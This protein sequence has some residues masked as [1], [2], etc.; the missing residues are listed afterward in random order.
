MTSTSTPVQTLRARTPED[1]LA[2]VPVVL[3][4]EP[5]E[6]VV[7]LTFGAAHPFHARVDLPERAAHADAVTHLLLDPAVQH[8]V[9]RVVLLLYTAADPDD[10]AVAATWRALCEGC[11]ERGLALVEALLVTE[12]R[13]HP[14]LGADGSAPGVRYDVSSHPFRAQA[15]LDGQV[16]RRSRD[17]LA[18]GIVADRAG[19]AR[20]A[21]A[22]SGLDGLGR[23]PSEEDAPRVLLA[24][25]EWVAA[26]VRRH[27]DAGTVPDDAEA[28]RLLR[29][30]GVVP[31]RDAAWSCL[32][33]AR[34]RESVRLL[35]DLVTRAPA[36]VLPPVATL[37]A[38]SAWQA[39]QG[40]LAWCALDRSDA[41]DPH[42]PLARILAVMLQQAVPPSSID[43]GFDWRSP[44]AERRQ[45]P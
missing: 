24:E 43:A 1:L 20:L 26:T 23:G 37:L 33:R 7:M 15:V 40:A 30:W 16:T 29:D 27:L 2:L 18:A 17:D 19:V 35:S 5:T 44:L 31:L 8:D 36:R 13:Y 41:V 32:T 9:D 3:G 14:L 22:L 42:Y 6:S 28:A 25:G 39:G 34:S 10:P 21:Q 4:F 45:G 38:W 12:S 11:E